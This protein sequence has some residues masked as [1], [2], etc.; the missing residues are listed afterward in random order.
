MRVN[1]KARRKARRVFE[2]FIT[3]WALHI[4]C[5]CNN[6][7]AA[8]RGLRLKVKVYYRE[9]FMGNI[10]ENITR[11]DILNAIEEIKGKRIKVPPKRKATKYHIKHENGYPHSE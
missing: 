3:S 10:P 1:T 5:G 8:R 2:H 11:D 4:I 7:L 6:L 9:N